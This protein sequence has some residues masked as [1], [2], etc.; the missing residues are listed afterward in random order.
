MNEENTI[1]KGEKG[2]NKNSWWEN[3]KLN[4]G[5][6]KNKVGAEHP[7]THLLILWRG[8]K[9]DGVF[10]ILT[11]NKRGWSIQYIDKE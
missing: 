9:E 7:K 1:E 8:I 3:N 2:D 10:N 4:M 6:V 11:K 5:S